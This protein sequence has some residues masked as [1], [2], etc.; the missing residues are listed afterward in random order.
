[1]ACGRLE[2]TDAYPTIGELTHQWLM[3]AVAGALV[4]GI[5]MLMNGT[6]ICDGITGDGMKYCTITR[7]VG[8]SAV[9]E[10]S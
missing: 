1:M 2:G 6:P 9:S 7:P 10:H 3:G 4:K 5:G 8:N